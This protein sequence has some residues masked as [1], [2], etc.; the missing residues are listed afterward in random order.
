MAAQ[1]TMQFWSVDLFKDL[2]ENER[3]IPEQKRIYTLTVEE[4]ASFLRVCPQT[5]RRYIKAKLLPAWDVGSL[6]RIQLVDFV[7]FLDSCRTNDIPDKSRP[8]AS[9]KPARARKRAR[10]LELPVISPPTGRFYEWVDKLK[11]DIKSKQ[12]QEIK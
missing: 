1:D 4:C 6:Y 10:Y 7:N 2:P 5:I 11:Q 12:A 8:E 3:G 9:K